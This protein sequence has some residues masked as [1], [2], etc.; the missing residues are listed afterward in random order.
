MKIR[1]TKRGLY[2]EM[3][4][5]CHYGNWNTQF[6][7]KICA[8][9][10]VIAPILQHYKGIY[11]NAGF[12][13]Y[14]F[15]LPWLL[16]RLIQKVQRN[17]IKVKTIVTLPLILF[18]IFSALIHDITV[19]KILYS[20]FMIVMLILLEY[21]CFNI[22]YVYQY[23]CMI[24]M[25][26]SAVLI[27]QYICYYVYDFHL[28]AVPIDALLDRSSNWIE[29]AKT[30]L[31]NIRGASNGFYRPS[32]FF[33]EPSHLFIY[34]FPTVCV[35]LFSKPMTA[36]RFG[37]ALFLSLGI[38]LSTSGMGMV[39]IFGVWMCYCFLYHNT[40]NSTLTNWQKICRFRNVIIT[41]CMLLMVLVLYVSVDSIRHTI[42][43]ILFDKSSFTG[44]FGQANTLVQELSGKSL[45]LGLTDD[46][47]DIIY[48]L[49][50]FFSTLYR[51]GLI[52]ILLSYWF[53]VG[54]VFQQKGAHFWMSVIILILSFLS[55]H[56]HGTF[57]MLFFVAFLMEGYKSKR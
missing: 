38:V 25:L 33:L 10:F 40:E 48:N 27:I 37:I 20:I 44:R 46:R 57:Y 36:Y 55:A 14:L 41:F 39:C 43:R 11:Q 29:G 9:L 35:L 30:G 13:V 31:I 42:N 53:Y 52:G 19:S 24:C 26:A 18:F 50:G 21:G 15:L 54:G 34:F 7:D 56:T 3:A 22:R 49:P 16:V 23:A 5:I 1:I 45:L 32:A 8:F 47:S 17:E 51:R 4:E 28:C 2:S 6:F 12:T